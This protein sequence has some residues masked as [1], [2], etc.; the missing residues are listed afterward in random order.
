[1]ISTDVKISAGSP[2]WWE[3]PFLNTTATHLGR[4]PS[5]GGC[6]EIQVWADSLSVRIEVNVI[7]D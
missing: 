7:D 2:V 6:T 5:D 3:N 1:M 4:G